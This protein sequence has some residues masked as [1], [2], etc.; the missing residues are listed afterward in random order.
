MVPGEAFPAE[1]APVV[2]PISS[3]V[4][5]PTETKG[6]DPPPGTS[7]AE[8]PLKFHCAIVACPQEVVEINNAT[9]TSF[10]TL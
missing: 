5:A 2:P 1:K 9:A 6:D 4:P 3:A 7:V 8:G 10:N